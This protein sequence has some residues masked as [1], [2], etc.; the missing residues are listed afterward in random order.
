M[1]YVYI[2]M[3]QLPT[4]ANKCMKVFTNF[5]YSH[6][7]ISFDEKLA[8]LYSFQGKNRK[9]LLVGGF[10]KETH[11]TYFHRKN[12]SLKEMVF[13][14]PVSDD[15]YNKIFNFIKQLADDEE[16][17]FNYVSALFMLTFGGVKSYKAY[18]C[19]EFVSEVLSMTQDIKI[20]KRPH[21]MKPKD[22]YK[23]LKP[24]KIRDGL[25]HANDFHFKED[26]FT[27]RIKF[28]VAVKKSL[29]S[30]REAICRATLHRTSKN[31]NYKNVNFYNED[32]VA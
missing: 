29:Y 11:D 27:Q 10:V 6:T 19:V 30:V 16:Y 25:I 5:D 17:I 24:F 1:K 18:H 15:D 28:D 21:K 13:K 7:S 32:T 8:T 22:L 12:V 9:V 2:T 4:L 26:S 20:P 3:V 23:V 31:F 14:V